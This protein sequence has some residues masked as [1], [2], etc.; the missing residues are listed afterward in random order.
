MHFALSGPS[1]QFDISTV[2]MDRRVSRTFFPSRLT[3]FNMSLKIV[4]IKKNYILKIED[5]DEY[6]GQ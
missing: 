5:M 4:S 2:E 1:A 6:D 3:Q